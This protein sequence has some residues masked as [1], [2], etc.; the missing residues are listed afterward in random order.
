MD[1]TPIVRTERG[2][3][4]AAAIGLPFEFHD[5]DLKKWVSVLWGYP[6]VQTGGRRVAGLGINRRPGQDPD[7]HRG[8]S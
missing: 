5:R 7:R 4:A 1:W 3:Y 8:I 6:D 2:R